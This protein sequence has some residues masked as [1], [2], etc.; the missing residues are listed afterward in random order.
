MAVRRRL[1]PACRQ[2]AIA[3]MSTAAEEYV[4]LA[5]ASSL[6]KWAVDRYRDRKQGPLLERYRVQFSKA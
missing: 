3:D 4:Q 2:E 6:L 1:S 5:T